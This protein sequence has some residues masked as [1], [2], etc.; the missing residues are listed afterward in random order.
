VLKTFIA[1]LG[2]ET[3]TFSPMPTGLRTFEEWMLYRGDATRR[4]P[5]TFSEPLHE[6]RRLTEE[7]QG[8]VVE[9]LAAFAQPSGV[10]PSDQTGK[11]SRMSQAASRTNPRTTIALA[12]R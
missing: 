7:R 1:C 2:T 9:S 5:N 8:Q 12:L 11:F 4:P 10:T 6:W 3:N